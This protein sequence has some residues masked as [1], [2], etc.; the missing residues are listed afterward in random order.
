MVELEPLM[1]LDM[2]M[3]TRPVARM[4]DADKALSLLE[5]I[6]L[7]HHL[8]A[9]II[10]THE[11]TVSPALEL[12]SVTIVHRFSSPAWLRTLREYLAGVSS[13]GVDV[14]QDERLVGRL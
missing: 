14:P 4:P 1:R 6:R 7:Q 13:A 9:R 12:C 2:Q 3:V 8:G 5:P 11:P 10:A